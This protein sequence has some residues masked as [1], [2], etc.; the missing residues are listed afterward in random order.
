MFAPMDWLFLRGLSREQRHWGAFVDVFRAAAPGARVHLLDLPGTGTELGRA[1]PL[2]VRGIVADLR[3]RHG[4]LRAAHPGPWGLLAMSLGGMVAMDWCAAHP[5]DFARLV[6]ANT[7]ASD[8][9]RPWDRMRPGALLTTVRV[10]LSRDPVERERRVLSMVTRRRT[11]LD[12]VAREW[13]DIHAT[14]PVTRATVLRQIGAALRFRAPPR[15]GL[16]VLVLSGAGDALASP[17]CSRALA[18]R[19]GARLEVHPEAGH[20]LALDAP[21]WLAERIVAWSGEPA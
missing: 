14:R 21:E 4:A 11:D 7:S 3:A 8:V 19:F 9:G 12:A 16:P 5:G 6:L 15:L 1:S 2:T 10:M 20:E 17:A 18:A 13:A